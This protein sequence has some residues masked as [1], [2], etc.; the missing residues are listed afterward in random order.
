MPDRFVR[1]AA[2]SCA[3]AVATPTRP[4]A[5]SVKVSSGQSRTAGP[6]ASR[7]AS[8]SV[9]AGTG[10]ASSAVKPPAIARSGAPSRRAASAATTVDGEVTANTETPE[11]GDLARERG[12]QQVGD[13]HGVS[14]STPASAPLRAQP[15]ATC[16]S[17]P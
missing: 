17:A 12:G 9:T 8:P 2:S 1:P 6:A 16:R 13:G 10:E 4:R 15:I 3:G 7:P 14:S 11:L 5:S